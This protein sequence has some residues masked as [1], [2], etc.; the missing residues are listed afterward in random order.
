MILSLICFNNQAFEFSE[1]ARVSIGVCSVSIGIGLGLLVPAI[2]ADKYDDYRKESLRLR[3]LIES[4]NA[5]NRYR[6][7]IRQEKTNDGTVYAIVCKDSD[8]VFQ[9]MTIHEHDADKYSYY[10]LLRVYSSLFLEKKGRKYLA[11]NY[12][13]QEH[14]NQFWWERSKELADKFEDLNIEYADNSFDYTYRMHKKCYD[15]AVYYM[16][17]YQV[18]IGISMVSGFLGMCAIPTLA[19]I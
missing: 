17:V 19:L 11:E 15:R 3:S 12:S 10:A 5:R 2:L 4:L 14:S 8:Y 6:P 18:G 9:Q 16:K 13:H 7:L 1:L